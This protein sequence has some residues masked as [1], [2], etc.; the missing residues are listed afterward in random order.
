MLLSLPVHDSTNAFRAFRRPLLDELLLQHD[1]FA[2]SPEM[3]FQATAANKR[4][5]EVPT[6]YTFRHRGQSN[7]SVV[8]MGW[9]YLRIALR[10]WLA[11]FAG[12]SAR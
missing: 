5:E 11:G 12:G 4:I 9:L 6:V 3:V 7:F 2:I 10:T 8:R 1:D